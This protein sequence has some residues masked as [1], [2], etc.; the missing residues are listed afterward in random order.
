MYK[1]ITY[2]EIYKLYIGHISLS[3]SKQWSKECIIGLL[4]L[5]TQNFPGFMLLFS[6]PGDNDVSFHE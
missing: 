4:N 2:I 1:F 6:F 3:S 5:A